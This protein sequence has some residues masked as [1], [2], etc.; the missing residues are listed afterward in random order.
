MT[1]MG[2]SAFRYES[3][4]R[5]NDEPARASRPFDVDRDG[6]V[7][8][9]GAGILIF[10]EL[11]MHSLEMPRL[12]VKSLVTEPV[13]MLAYLY[14]TGPCR[15]GQQSDANALD[16]ANLA[17]KTCNICNAHGTSTP[18]GIRPKLK[19]S[20]EYLANMPTT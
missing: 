5:R 13:V 4:F 1:G 19:Q 11:N 10:E 9:E 6:F 12:T 20:R 2:I 16:D 14:A 18:L 17:R 7:L 3:G 15:H 8:S